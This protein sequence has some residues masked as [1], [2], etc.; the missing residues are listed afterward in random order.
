M[1]VRSPKSIEGRSPLETGRL[2]G[3]FLF[4]RESGRFA[5]REQG[6]CKP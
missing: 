5:P 4:D 3:I 1:A 2:L 6:D